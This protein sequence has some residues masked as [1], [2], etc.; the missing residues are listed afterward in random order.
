MAEVGFKS[1]LIAVIFIVIM[2][3]CNSGQSFDERA[4][5]CYSKGLG[6]AIQGK[7]N[8]S[9]DE[10]AEALNIEPAFGP[11]KYSLELIEDAIGQKIKSKTAIHLFKGIDYR[12]KGKW[13]AAIAEYNKA[14]EI[15]P[16]YAKSYDNRGS[17]YFVLSDFDN[18]ISDSSKAIE[19]NPNY[20]NA[21]A[22]RAGAYYF[23]LQY[24]EA[25][26]RGNV[27][28]DKGDT[29]KA[30]SDWKRACELGNCSE[31]GTINKILCFGT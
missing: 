25:I 22:T 23:I 24:D 3:G 12:H 14:I 27:Y 2:V 18:A 16:K 17:V 30:C 13:D 20:A 11:A 10:F 19:I 28:D 4:V 15:N 31:W 21:Y 26:N 1:K 29:E 9:K 8:E 5:Q 7:L 6:Y